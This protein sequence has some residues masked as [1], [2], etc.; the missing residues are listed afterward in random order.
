MK[1]LNFFGVPSAGKTTMSTGLFHMCKA[2]G[3]RCELISELAREWAYADRKI[4]SF[5]QVYLTASQMHREDTL[6]CRRKVDFVVTD[7]PVLLNIF[8]SDIHNPGFLEPLLDLHRQFEERYPSVNIYIRKNP[9]SMFSAEGRHHSPD[10]LRE[11]SERLDAFLRRHAG[12]LHV[13]ESDSDID[14]GRVYQIAFGGATIPLNTMN[15][16][17]RPSDDIKPRMGSGIGADGD[18][19]PTI[20]KTHS[21]AVA[22]T[23]GGETSLRGLTPSE[24]ERLQG[25]SGS[26]TA[27]P[28]RG[29]GASDTTRQKSIGNSMA[30][31]C[32]RWIGTRIGECS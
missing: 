14:L 2:R 20:T 4:G 19:C 6:L 16:L 21:H 25:F 29:R 10:Q 27:V 13:L 3:H 1:R 15:M 8:Y 9:K 11:L 26:Y 28:F 22:S 18:P 31:A 23:I 7:S 30:V 12:N 24:C 17:G 5:D 32:M